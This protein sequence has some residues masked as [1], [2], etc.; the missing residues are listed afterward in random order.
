MATN[1]KNKPKTN[2]RGT[3]E[4]TQGTME[5]FLNEQKAEQE[6]ESATE[7][8]ESDITVAEFRVIDKHM[9]SEAIAG[10]SA[11]FQKNVCYNIPRKTK[12][13]L[14]SMAACK[15]MPNGYCKYE[16]KDPHMHNVDVGIEGARIA[17]Q[18]YGGLTYGPLSMP[19]VV[20]MNDKQYWV[21][22]V[23][24]YDEIRNLRVN[25]WQFQEVV[26]VWGDTITE[27]EHG[28]AIVQA[29]GL[30]KVIL[31]VVPPQLR[32]IWVKNYLDGADD[33]DPFA[34]AALPGGREGLAGR[35]KEGALPPA[36]KKKP[37]P[38]KKDPPKKQNGNG[39]K[40]PPTQGGMDLQKAATQ[41]A[42]KLKAPAP[43]VI[44]FSSSTAF[45]NQGAATVQFVRALSS[46]P[47][48]QKLKKKFDDWKTAKT[49]AEADAEKGAG[50]EE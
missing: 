30:R 18:A 5:D 10:T 20:M 13:G 32:Q 35:G 36:E 31:S 25:A 23:E 29:K 45:N 49:K 34:V 40:A 48:F 38:K 9:M 26:L 1:D 7:M 50:T 47:D 16:G 21:V 27:I 33:F 3:P 39:K 37:T 11:L 15:R 6:L 14:K 4:P 43:E 12:S 42:T 22:E 28:A 2:G 41:V 46:E 24:C 8:S 44:E 17:A 19:T